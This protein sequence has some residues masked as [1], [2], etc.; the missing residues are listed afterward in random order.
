MVCNMYKRYK[1]IIIIYINFHFSVGWGPECRRPRWLCI[2][3]RQG[4]ATATDVGHRSRDLN[5][6]RP[7]VAHLA[8]GRRIYILITMI[9]IA[10][11]ITIIVI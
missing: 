2:G 9:I 8:R 4:S 10:F 7:Q 5:A 3:L 11:V 6:A 1:H